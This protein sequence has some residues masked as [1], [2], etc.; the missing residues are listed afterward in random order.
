MSQV[1]R[2]ERT[3][4]KVARSLLELAAV[5]ADEDTDLL[6][7][8]T[9][10][11]EGDDSHP[12]RACVG[13]NHGPERLTLTVE[14]AARSLGVSR[15]HAYELAARGEIPTLRLGRRILVPKEAL[16]RMMSR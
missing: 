5:L 9:L 14:E 2:P 3:S 13:S 16:V 12:H 10:P 1:V 8:P 6:H 7:L 15:A 4:Q 11:S